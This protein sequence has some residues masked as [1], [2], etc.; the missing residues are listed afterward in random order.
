MRKCVLGISPFICLALIIW[1]LSY[2]AGLEQRVKRMR[3]EKLS[4]IVESNRSGRAW[5]RVLRRES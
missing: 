3:R 2:A 4:E 5:R 1:L